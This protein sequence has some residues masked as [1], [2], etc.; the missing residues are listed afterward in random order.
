MEERR[1]M[2]GYDWYERKNFRNSR[3]RR[4]H[5]WGAVENYIYVITGASVEGEIGGIEE[6]A[7]EFRRNDGACW[8]SKI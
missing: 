3:G 7:N 8:P 2:D 4:S 1:K 5:R 6:K